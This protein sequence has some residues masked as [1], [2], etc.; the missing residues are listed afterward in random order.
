MSDQ[1]SEECSESAWVGDKMKLQIIVVCLV[2]LG[3]LQGSV[4]AQDWSSWTEAH[5]NW[6][7][8]GKNK[9]VQYRWRASTP[10]GARSVRCNC[11]TH[12]GSQT[13]RPW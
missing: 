13:R 11:V 2:V 10:S 1:S 12:S 5:S 3:V 9:G 8:L 4:D 6:F 7:M